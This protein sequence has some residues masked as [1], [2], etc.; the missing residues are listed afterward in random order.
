MGAGDA[1]GLPGARP[2]QLRQPVL[3]DHGAAT[4]QEAIKTVREMRDRQ[5][6]PLGG[7]DGARTA[8]LAQM[9]SELLDAPEE[10]S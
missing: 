2:A 4:V 7:N 8:E 5:T 9:I 1:V 10:D 6:R 3:T